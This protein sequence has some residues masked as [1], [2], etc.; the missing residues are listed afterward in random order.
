MGSQRHLQVLQNREIFNACNFRL[1]WRKFP[2]VQDYKDLKAFYVM[3]YTG[4]S[5]IIYCLISAFSEAKQ[6]TAEV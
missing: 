5:S 3:Y 2:T 6:A 4:N 1:K